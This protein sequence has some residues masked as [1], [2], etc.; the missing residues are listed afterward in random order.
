MGV[1]ASAEIPRSGN[2]VISKQRSGWRRSALTKENN[3]NL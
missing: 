3:E 1:Q 2:E